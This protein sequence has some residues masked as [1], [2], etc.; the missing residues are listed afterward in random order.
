M[1]AHMLSQHSQAVTP[2]IALGKLSHF[3]SFL[4][5]HHCTPNFF[6][7]KVFK[8]FVIMEVITFS[9]LF[10]ATCTHIE[11]SNF[12]FKEI[13]SEFD[14]QRFISKPKTSFYRGLSSFGFQTYSKLLKIFF[15]TFI[16]IFS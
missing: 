10:F 12:T 15:A 3:S 14:Q 1:I 16:K 11:G 8:I 5:T 4:N 6:L 7:K 2:P 9:I 13:D